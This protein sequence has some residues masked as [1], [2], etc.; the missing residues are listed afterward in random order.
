METLFWYNHDKG[1]NYSTAYGTAYT[2][3]SHFTVDQH[4]R[5]IRQQYLPPAW[6]S[7]RRN[8][9]IKPP[10]DINFLS[11]KVL[12]VNMPLYGIP[13]N[14]LPWYLIYVGQNADNFNISVS[15]ELL[16]SI[17]AKELKVGRNGNCQ[18]HQQDHRTVRCVLELED[19]TSKKV[20][21]KPR[22]RMEKQPMTFCG[23][24]QSLRREVAIRM[25][26]TRQLKTS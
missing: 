10:M 24:E 16:S 22:S 7:L 3:R 4:S 13:E 5:W 2:S 8:V 12:T 17:Q 6:Y 18:G 23:V 21:G 9:Y 14:S 1:S 15:S 20:L 26:Q 25:T 19:E 11:K